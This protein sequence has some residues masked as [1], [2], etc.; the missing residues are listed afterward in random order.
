ME[1]HRKPVS[2]LKKPRALSRRQSNLFPSPANRVR[3]DDLPHTEFA[4]CQRARCRRPGNADPEP[5]RLQKRTR[6][7]RFSKAPSARR[8]AIVDHREDGARPGPRDA[9]ALLRVV[10]SC[11]NFPCPMCGSHRRY[12][13]SSAGDHDDLPCRSRDR[14]SRHSCC[15]S[16]GRIFTGGRRPFHVRRIGSE[17]YGAALCLD[18]GELRNLRL[19]EHAHSTA[20]LCSMF[21]GRAILPGS[22]SRI[23]RE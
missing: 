19:R 23:R 10:Q 2:Q 21:R 3:W 20:L 12:V 7:F 4:A 8:I 1:Y 18:A 5:R 16:S 9:P 13:Q 11:S 6:R 15:R 14:G 22:R 17:L